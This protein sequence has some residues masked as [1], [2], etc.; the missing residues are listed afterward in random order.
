[1]SVKPPVF[2]SCLS[3]TQDCHFG[4]KI[5][6]FSIELRNALQFNPLKTS[7]EFTWAGV[8]GKCVFIAK[9]SHLQQV[10]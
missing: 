5:W 9:S 1:M 8:Y 6:T 3:F 7:V 2:H 10:I 4:T